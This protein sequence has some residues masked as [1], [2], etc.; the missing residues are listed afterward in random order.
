MQREV[1]SLLQS[2]LE[3]ALSVVRAN[4]TVVEGLGAYLEGL[5]FFLYLH[6]YALLHLCLLQL[7]KSNN[8]CVSF[9][10]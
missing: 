7:A 4:P 1:K 2:A 10:K 3:V 8:I 6:N 5:S 9:L